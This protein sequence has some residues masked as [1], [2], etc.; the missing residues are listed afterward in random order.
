MRPAAWLQRIAAAI[1]AGN[2]HRV[3]LA[4]V[5]VN[6]DDL[7]DVIE[8]GLAVM[9]TVGAGVTV[10]VARAE[11]LPPVP[12]AVAVYVVVTVGLTPGFHRSP[13]A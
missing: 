8:A 3:A 11:V 1:R 12:V 10:T 5:T 6:V 7:P 4:A 9:V 2:R 13:A